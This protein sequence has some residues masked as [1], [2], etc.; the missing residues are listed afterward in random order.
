MR[1]LSTGVALALCGAALASAYS[2][3][4][5]SAVSS[6]AR[7][8]ALRE[9]LVG[10]PNA[11]GEVGDYLLENDQIRVVI[12][13]PGFSRGFGV[14]GGSLI[15]ADLVRPKTPGDA[16]GGKGLDL[17]G[18]MFPVF[19]V[20]ALV[21]ESVAVENDGKNGET[22]SILVKGHGGDFLSMTRTLNQAITN[23]HAQPDGGLPTLLNPARDDGPPQIGYE[24]RYELPPGE[25]YVRL[26]STIIN[27][28]ETDLE[29]PWPKIKALLNSLLKL[30]DS[31]QVPMGFVLLFGAGND[32]FVPGSGYGVRWLLD[33]NYATATEKG[34][35][36]PALP[37]LV[38]PGLISTSESGISYGFFALPDPQVQSYVAA[39]N[40]PPAD[41][42]EGPAVNRYTDAYGVEV[43]EDSMLIPF[44]AS[45]FTA[46]FYGQ[47][48]N[49]LPAGESFTI[50]NYFVVGDGDAASVMN[51]VYA[52]QGLETEELQ[53][54]VV[55]EALGTP[56]E[57]ASV[58]VYAGGRPVN[59]FFTDASGRFRGRM[60]AGVY[61]AR[62]LHDPMVSQKV[63][64]ELKDGGNVVRLSVPSPARIAVH[65]T[66]EGGNPLPAKVSV[67][68]R[69]DAK[70]AGQEPR[71]FLY[72]LSAGERWR[73]VDLDRDDAN[74]PGTLEYLEAF[75]FTDIEGD[76][77]LEVPP[78]RDYEVWIS[79]GLEYDVEKLRIR[80]SVTRP[81]DLA[82]SLK[83]VVD[84]K[85]YVSGDFHMH[86]DPSLDSDLSLETRVAASAAAGLE[87]LVATDHNF[88]TDYG[89]T[90]DRLGLRDY[91]TSLVGLEM[92]TLESGHFNG[93]PLKRQVGRVTKGAME[94]SLKTPDEI[95]A[96]IRE[97]GELGPE[98]TIVQV[99][100]P[101]DSLLGYF[102]QYDFN[103]L[104]ATVDDLGRA[105][106]GN[107]V[108]PSGRPF[109]DEMGQS[110]FSFA[111]DAMEILNGG[112]IGQ[113][114]SA[115]RPASL[116][117][118]TIPPE[119]LP[120][121][122]AEP[123][124]VLC[125]DDGEIAFPGAIDDWFNML[126]L[127][128]RYVGTG[129]SDSH[130][131]HD[132]G[133]PRTYMRV[134]TD[135]PRKVGPAQVV[136][137]FQRRAI[138]LTN[139]PFL[140]MFVDGKPIGSDVVRAAGTVSVKLVVQA[141]PWVDVKRGALWA[142][143][144]AVSR[145]DVAM[146]PATRRWESTFEIPVEKDTWFVA[147]VEGDGNL[148]PV[149]P[150]LD[151]PPVQIDDA[152]SSIGGAFGFGASPFGDLEPGPVQRWTPF[153]LTNPVW[154]DVGAAGF[155]A[156]GVVPRQCKGLG[157]VEV[158]PAAM[159][160]S[161]RL[162]PAQARKRALKRTFKP[163]V[164]GDIPRVHGDY[165]DVR[166]L[167]QHFRHGH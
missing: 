58:L 145:F 17:F 21:P 56:V 137:A 114:H 68:A 147:E 101:R 124:T 74:D 157:L 112:V 158:D 16:L 121:L 52:L 151:I 7:Q 75:E 67:V 155:E 42:P 99:N 10:G 64:F 13:G 73:H 104:T 144:R 45:A 26:R 115:M 51:T 138:T 6:N 119:T 141:A 110:T 163:A 11:L 9:E 30:G 135:D 108:H 50:T 161:A 1:R 94:W 81:A 72:D 8:V 95:F 54:E 98:K 100:H 153:A 117:G 15:D 143:G 127:G 159:E 91:M 106:F 160:K 70:F 34:L 131:A 126:N 23:S 77:V 146:N 31:F 129:N 82:A 102:E 96:A 86:A 105:D 80:P 89:P 18:E 162:N 63:K 48:P 43:G 118:L 111:F 19:F 37:G 53:G 79:R 152:L 142:N 150:P 40:A 140:E 57:K 85:G 164:F 4:N 61:E 76:A 107:L 133:I 87:V 60:P 132:V 22:A 62:V 156:P 109:F 32:V 47:A 97:Q 88:V 69:Y 136:D 28:T 134:D 44:L 55:D 130:D 3:Q 84:T 149:A 65:V 125:D 128:Y 41:N 14:Y 20:Q 154:V 93:F 12:Q 36:F 33:D 113:T 148:F 59:Q 123:G 83:R 5:E 120:N 35:G 92:T 90:I 38:T 24:I 165:Q 49:P 39:Q 2:C 139:G 25:R 166:T 122:P 103:A 78:D 71:K 167:F 46:V 116:E 66:D 29:M 27:E